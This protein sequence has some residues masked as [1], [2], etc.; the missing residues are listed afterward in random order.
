VASLAEEASTAVYATVGDEVI[1][2][3]AYYEALQRG[4]RQ[5]FYHGKIPEGEMARF[6]R[7]VGEKIVTRTLLLQE[8]ARKGIEPD[9]DWV[10]AR[11]EGL[12]RR[13]AESSR[14]QRERDR[15]LPELSRALE[16]ES[17]LRRLEQ[18]VRDVAPPDEATLRA[19]YAGSPDQ[20]TE[21]ERF[22]VSTILLRVEPSAPATVWAAARAEGDAIMAEL[23]A[24]ADFGE[25]ARLR[26]GDGSASRGGDMGY[27]HR[28]MLGEG[29]QQAVDA[30]APGELSE[31][32]TL[33]EGVAI[34]R[35]EDRPERQLMAFD[36]VHDRARGL[37]MREQ[38]EQ[39]WQDLLARLRAS[40]EITVNED[41]YLPLPAEG[42][43]SGR[44]DKTTH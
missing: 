38:G 26:S 15:L 27:L 32:V 40:T 8:A 31:P 41:H 21:P 13:Y 18:Q 24:G 39:A 2:L 37:W 44:A 34:F 33:L 11:L 7:E 6:Q 14:W 19:Y 36:E 29:A 5:R 12:E 43:A 25:L 3:A 1:T 10:Q 23:R 42:T 4:V 35:L 22:R 20:F 28:G 16:T 30:L 17:R 9:R